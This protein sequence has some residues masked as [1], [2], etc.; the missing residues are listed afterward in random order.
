MLIHVQQDSGASGEQAILSGTI[1]FHQ[2]RHY[3]LECLR[4]L[5]GYVTTEDSNNDDRQYYL[6]V[7]SEISQ[8]SSGHER[9]ASSY[10]RKCF[11]ALSEIEMWLQ[12]LAEKA[13]G[14][15]ALGQS[16][17][18]VSEDLIRFQQS[19]LMQQ[20]ESLSAIITLLVKTEH[21]VPGDFTKL[22]EKLSRLERWNQLAV[23]YIPSIIAFAAEYGSSESGNSLQDARMLD[24]DILGKEGSSTWTNGTLHALTV[25]L[26]L[27]EYSSWYIERPIDPS[28]DRV[29]LAG[30]AVTRAEALSR[31]LRDGAL[32]C[33]LA[34]CSTL[35]PVRKY[36][37]TRSGLLDFLLRDAPSISL[38]DTPISSYF[39]ELFMEQL[40]TFT[41]AFITNLPDTLRRFKSEED[42][43]RRL[44]L[45]GQR[46]KGYGT[47]LEQDLY[48]ERFMVIISFTYQDRPESASAFWDDPD[49]NLYGFLQ[50]A[51]KRVSTPQVA[52]FCLMLSSVAEGNECASCAHRFLQDD[53]QTALP[54]QRK[55]S[56][57]TWSL[58]FEEL[59]LY[60]TKARD[61]S[62]SHP[63]S[64]LTLPTNKITDVSEPESVLMLECYLRLAANVCRESTE[65]VHWILLHPSFKMV[66]TLL[67]LCAVGVPGRIQ[68]CAF[69]L[70]QALATA[71]EK[72]YCMS[73]WMHL[74]QWASGAFGPSTVPSRAQ[75]MPAKASHH[76]DA[77]F[78]SI[79]ADPEMATEFTALLRS[80][81]APRVPNG[82]LH[83]ELPFPEELGSTY[84]M[85]GIDPYLDLLFGK[86][87]TSTSCRV[88]DPLQR[89]SLQYNIIDFGATCLEIFNE[90]LIVLANQSVLD[91]DS[92]MSTSSLQTYMTLHPF[93]RVMDWIFNL[94]VLKEVFAASH[95]STD[96]LASASEDSPLLLLVLR[97]VD[98]MNLVLD[99]QS[100]Y[101]EILRPLV[102]STF[103]ERRLTVF[104]SSVTSFQ[105]AVASNLVL[106]VD[107]AKYSGIGIHSL[108]TSS[109]LLLGKLASSRRLNYQGPTN[110]SGGLP[111][112]RL[113][114]ILE[115]SGQLESIQRQFA[116]AL[117]F[118]DRELEQG[119]H[120]SRWTVKNG[121]MDF[122]ILC[123]QGA[124]GKPSLAH[125]TL[126]FSCQ[127]DA[128][129]IA[130]DGD[131][132]Q[133]ASLFHAVMNLA[134]AYPDGL[135]SEI[136]N[137]ATAL[138]LKAFQVLK[139]LWDSTLTSTVALIELQKYDFTRQIFLRQLT[140]DANAT[141]DGRMLN[142]DGFFTSDAAATFID[143]L[144][145]RNV[146]LNLASKTLRF[147]QE[148]DNAVS[149]PNL[150]STFLGL[151]HDGV[152]GVGFGPSILDLSDFLELE[153][154]GNVP[155]PPLTF[156]ANIGL[157]S[158]AF[159][160][161]GSLGDS[162]MKTLEDLISLRF[163]Q[164]QDNGQLASQ[165]AL[166]KAH[167]EAS[168]I[169]LAI[170]TQ[171]HMRQID[172]IRLQVLRCWSSAIMTV[173]ICPDLENNDKAQIMSQSME[174]LTPKLE[175]FAMDTK[176]EAIEIARLLHFI[177]VQYYQPSEKDTSKTRVDGI[178]DR[179]FQLFQATIHGIWIPQ[180]NPELREVLYGICRVYLTSTTIEK[181]GDDLRKSIVQTLKV[182][183]SKLLETICDDALGELGPR[184]TSA[185]ST[186]QCF[187]DVARTVNSKIVSDTLS[188]INFVVVLVEAIQDLPQELRETPSQG[189]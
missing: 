117:E 12:S 158:N 127:Q 133:G 101:L 118:T 27:A 99:Y 120:A 130:E 102:S 14:V 188:R 8:A 100:T 185:L 147:S 128:I 11:G 149:T 32:Q 39:Q 7:V 75:S 143:H 76:Q 83:D 3:L 65:A 4:L 167:G 28:V 62:I 70:L 131:F 109:L 104:N 129:T 20:H 67:F 82:S 123:L 54:K 150:L 145:I 189:K 138:R 166:E 165:P 74:D 88:D 24:K 119:P 69:S 42:N 144:E 105:D 169:V 61:Q 140:I 106:V 34:I 6:D 136:E 2:K 161:T 93:G 170:R 55:S 121:I 17:S 122:L 163:N 146:V 139:A 152:S 33:M 176:D 85:P 114:A 168:S 44:L 58:I 10:T 21:T 113:T 59:T 19:S 40:E 71:I 92:S 35:K 26:W 77:T 37:P 126:G 18:S 103:G 68:A 16:L 90:N 157:E 91:V 87:L 164:L 89:R 38:E 43:Q 13:Q 79:A 63:L 22:L 84:R 73:L 137:W 81:T 132:V 151:N 41:N 178:N 53:G 159:L 175:Q 124:H 15:I 155:F 80:L 115:E 111:G 112:N 184:R 174:I 153:P 96:E 47:G 179:V 66:E 72:E 78:E 142:D 97:C 94:D 160:N 50:W 110:R 31:A 98:L 29:D 141:F 180:G 134:L 5:L 108:T 48:L 56:S 187:E 172:R 135:E 186:L 95:Q 9:N 182:A 1:L 156:F 171:L 107:L 49:G 46:G 177:V 45:S 52:A 30:E 25:V 148:E 154:P 57:L 183:G 162:S 116:S 51:S 125:A 64:H 173:L 36:N 181:G 86:L 60:T 23:H